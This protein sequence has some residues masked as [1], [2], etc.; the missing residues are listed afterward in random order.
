ML[1][2]GKDRVEGSGGLGFIMSV[3]LELGEADNKVINGKR[4]ATTQWNSCRARRRTW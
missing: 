1:A 4:Q 3:S 2:V